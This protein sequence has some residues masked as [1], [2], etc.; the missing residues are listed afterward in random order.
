VAKQRIGTETLFR[1]HAEF[2]AAFLFRLGVDPSNIDDLVQE[3]FLI[4]HRKGGYEPGPALP[5][6]WLGAIA[7]RLASSSRRLRAR[8][9]EDADQD[10]LA[11]ATSTDTSP[12]KSAQLKDSLRRVQEALDTM[13]FEHR[14]AFVLYELEGM[15][16][17]EIADTLSVPICTVYSR[18]HMARQL[19]ARA[20]EAL[21]DHE[22]RKMARSA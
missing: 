13:D 11:Q 22:R 1:E 15:P 6:T 2:V 8:S 10:R 9:R 5:R 17:Q 3:V 14:A 19:F 20:H 4:A 18:L 21:V 12:E 16:C 7:V